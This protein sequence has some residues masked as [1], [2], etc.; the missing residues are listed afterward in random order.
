MSEKDPLNIL[1]I[2]ASARGASSMSRQLVGDLIAALQERHNDVHVTR[3]N[4]ATGLPFVDEE[5]VAANNT[6]EEERDDEQRDKLALSDQLVAELAA[7]DVLVIGTPIYN[8]SI[9]ASL[10]AWVDMIAR[11]RLTFR[12]TKDGVEGL[13]ADRKTYVVVPSGGVPVGSPVDF[14]T[15]YL[16]HVLGFVGITDIEFIGA[17]GAD[18]GNHEALDAARARI[19]ELVHLGPRAA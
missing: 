19:A 4:V 12:Y 13:L 5:W 10:K 1:H 18:R 15:P 7:A 2:N 17:R 9:P 11:A 8:F 6:P 14:A 3:R 16:R